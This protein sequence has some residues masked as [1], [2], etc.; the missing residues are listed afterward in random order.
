MT[1]SP[2]NILVCEIDDKPLPKVID[3][4]VAKAVAGQRLTDATLNT[5][6]GRMIGTPA[7]MSPE[8]AGVGAADVDIRSDVYSLGV[9]LYE[10]LSGAPAAG[11]DRIYRRGLARARAT[12]R[13]IGSAA[14]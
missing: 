13:R 2:A 5:Q 14:A 11:C 7:Y 10:L 1:S 8:Q 12:T 6:I 4:G 9:V 3:F